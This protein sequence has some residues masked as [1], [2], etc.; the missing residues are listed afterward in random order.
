MSDDTEQMSQKYLHSQK[1]K[2]Y[3]NKELNFFTS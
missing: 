1:K 2:A 3:N